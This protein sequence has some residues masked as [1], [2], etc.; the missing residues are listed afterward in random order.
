MAPLRDKLNVGERCNY[1]DCAAVVGRDE[2][3]S[4]LMIAGLPAGDARLRRAAQYVSATL[5][6]WDEPLR[7]GNAWFDR[8]DQAFSKPTRP[9]RNAAIEE[10]EG[11]IRR[12]ETES[13]DPKWIVENLLRSRSPRLAAGRHVGRMFMGFFLASVPITVKRD[14]RAA[15]CRSMD[16]LLFVLAVYRAE[17]GTY[18]EKLAQLCPNYLK[19]I[20]EDPFGA[21]PFRYK[22]EPKGYVLY[23]VGFNGKD[24]GGHHWYQEVDQGLPPE[25]QPKIPKDADDIFLRMPPSLE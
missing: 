9:Q 19:V 5:V 1:L 23:S 22:R 6:D 15:A 4:L 12:M 11:E 17:H 8:L 3:G 2:P 7:M 16:E 20:P 13:R 18:P 21:G 14:D 10:L 25:K 24:D